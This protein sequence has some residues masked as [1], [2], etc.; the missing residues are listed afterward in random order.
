MA[1]SSLTP[2]QVFI[3]LPGLSPFKRIVTILGVVG[4]LSL[5]LWIA[6]YQHA[7]WNDVSV[8]GSTI[9]AVL[10]GWFYLVSGYDHS[11]AIYD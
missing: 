2:E 7:R 9:V 1:S 5:I 6:V 10:S 11:R 8:Y 3:G 4:I